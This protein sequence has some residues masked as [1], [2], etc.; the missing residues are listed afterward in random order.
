MSFELDPVFH[1]E[2]MVKILHAQGQ[3]YYATKLCEEIIRKNPENPQMRHLL[4][5]IKKGQIP[6]KIPAYQAQV[7]AEA[8]ILPIQDDDVTEPGITFEALEVFEAIEEMEEEQKLEVSAPLE[9]LQTEEGLAQSSQA[10]VLR[11]PLVERKVA[12]LE[13]LLVKIQERKY[14]IH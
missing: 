2:T 11:D 4:E 13:D 8:E 1:T 12:L 10:E 6:E 7:V 3:V 9:N 14:E 5:G